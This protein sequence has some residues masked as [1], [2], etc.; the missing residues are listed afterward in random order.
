MPIRRRGDGAAGHLD[1]ARQR[2]RR[3][4]RAPRWSSAAWSSGARAELRDGRSRSDRP[5]VRRVVP[6]LRA[7]PR[8]RCAS[9][10]SFEPYPGVQFDDDDLSRRRVP[11]LRLGCAVAEVDVDLDTGEVTVRDVVAADDIGKAIHPILAEGQVEGGTL[12]ARRLRHDRGD[13]AGRR[14]LPERPPGD[15]PDPD[16]RSMRRASRR[17]WS[18]SRSAARRTAPRAS[19]SCPWTSARRRSSRRSTTRPASGSTTAGTPERILAALHGIKPPP[20]RH[21]TVRERQLRRRGD[22]GAPTQARSAPDARPTRSRCADRTTDD[23]D[24]YELT[25]NGARRRRS[26]C[27]ACAACST[28]CARTSA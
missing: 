23:R 17:S 3:W 25:V 5:T 9:T 16:R 26:T 2:A 14:P 20:R 18:R 22:A 15:L 21:P 10:S 7:R 27:R 8:R 28:C 19:A 11:G 24:G 13:Q 12:Q 4:R 1:R 6:R